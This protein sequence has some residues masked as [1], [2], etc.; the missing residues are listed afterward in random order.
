MPGSDHRRGPLALK[1]NS[2]KARVISVAPW[3]FPFIFF[4][5]LFIR[6]ILDLGASLP[7]W[8]WSNEPNGTSQDPRNGFVRLYTNLIFRLSADGVRLDTQTLYPGVFALFLI[9]SSFYGYLA[10]LD[11]RARCARRNARANCTI[12]RKAHAALHTKSGVNDVFAFLLLKLLEIPPAA[13]RDDE[14]SWERDGDFEFF[15]YRLGK[16]YGFR[17]KSLLHC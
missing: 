7:S 10:F 13:E 11:S 12:N 2:T 15:C 16:K 5:Y 4:L 3:N 1:E 9:L 6:T 17:E 14:V 8:R